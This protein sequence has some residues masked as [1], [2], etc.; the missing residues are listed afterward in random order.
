MV[1][2]KLPV[3]DLKKVLAHTASEVPGCVHAALVRG[4]D[5]AGRTSSAARLTRPRVASAP[6]HE[7]TSGQCSSS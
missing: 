6:A 1:R 7:A 4:C 5:E 2:I 3:T